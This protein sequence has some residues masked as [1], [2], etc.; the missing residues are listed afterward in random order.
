MYI[1]TNQNEY[2]IAWAWKWAMKNISYP[3]CFKFPVKKITSTLSFQKMIYTSFLSASVS[4]CMAA[5]V[6]FNSVVVS[7]ISDTSVVT[8]FICGAD[9]S[10]FC[11]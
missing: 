5:T 1:P 6:I 11:K 9:L 7:L 4:S 10:D 3:S 2:A 8:L